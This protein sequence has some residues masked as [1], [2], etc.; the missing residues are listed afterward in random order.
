M[1]CS[2]GY[3]SNYYEF[4]GVQGCEEVFTLY[5][6]IWMLTGLNLVAFFTG[7][8]TTAVLGSIKDLVRRTYGY[9]V[10]REFIKGPYVMLITRFLTLKLHPL[11]LGH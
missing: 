11:V 1:L 6:L 10:R 2:G 8:L 9:K 5:V 7:I 3:L 4:V